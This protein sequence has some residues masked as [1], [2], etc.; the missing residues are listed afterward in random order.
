M[1]CVEP[2]DLIEIGDDYAYRAKH[3]W[4]EIERNDDEFL[5]FLG[6]VVAVLE[7]PEPPEPASG[8]GF[9][10]YGQ[11]LLQSGLSFPGSTGK[12]L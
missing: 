8:C 9:C 5:T 12:G 6:E 1:L 10:A 4:L 2:V 11:Q 3:T 7:R